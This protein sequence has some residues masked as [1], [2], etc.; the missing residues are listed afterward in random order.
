MPCC[1]K[2]FWL[3]GIALLGTISMSISKAVSGP[4]GPAP[5]DQQKETVNVSDQ[6]ENRAV[7]TFGGGCFW[8]V[9][10]VFQEL[11]GVIDVTS[12]YMGCD[13]ENPTYAQV[14]QETTGHAEVCQI[15]YDPER[16]SYQKLLEV[17]FATH[18]PT[19]LN[20]QGNDFGTQ[21][22]SVVFYHNE[23]QK[24]LAETVKQKLNESGAY[25]RPVVT[26]ISPASTYYVA[27]NYHQNYFSL[28]PRQPYCQGVIVPKMA[29]FREV[30]ANDLKSR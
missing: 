3:V 29:K 11:E 13:V 27:E 24:Q 17:F 26:E 1:N 2:T 23:A 19:T 12:G 16:V 8:C 6:V 10:A 14:C 4:L 15:T 18:D 9:E 28:N 25:S 30:F 22:R 7:A 21:Y 20:R 5:D